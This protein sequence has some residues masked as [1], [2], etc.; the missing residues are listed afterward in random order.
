MV[1]NTEMTKAIFGDNALAI[2]SLATIMN[3]MCNLKAVGT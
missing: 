2:N 1:L 3:G